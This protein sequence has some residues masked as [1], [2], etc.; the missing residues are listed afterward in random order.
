MLRIFGSTNKT[1]RVIPNKVYDYVSMRKPVI[2]ADTLAI[3]E[4]FEDDELMLV[5]VADHLS[6]ANAIMTLKDNRKLANDIAQKG[7]KNF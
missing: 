4:L 1:K 7:I 2:T 3:R 6:L 5:K